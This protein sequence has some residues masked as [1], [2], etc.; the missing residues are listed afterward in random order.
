M[1]VANSAAGNTEV[2]NF[3]GIPCRQNSVDTLT[4]PQ[5]YVRKRKIFPLDVN[6]GSDFSVAF[7]GS[8]N[9]FRFIH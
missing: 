8:L 5:E 7:S 6:S 2:K 4:V 9:F 3:D 1:R